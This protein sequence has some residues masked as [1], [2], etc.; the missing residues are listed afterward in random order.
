MQLHATTQIGTWPTIS[1]KAFSV[2]FKSVSMRDRPLCASLIS[3][4]GADRV[5]GIWCVQ[6]SRPVA[7]PPPPLA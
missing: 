3:G 2:G 7:C 4:T 5:V 6:V 1:C